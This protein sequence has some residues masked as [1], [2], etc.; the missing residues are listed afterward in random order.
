MPA[1]GLEPVQAICD[2]VARHVRFDYQ[3]A[4]ATRSAFDVFQERVGVCRDYAHL[5]LTFCRCFNIPARYCERVS[6]RYRCSVV[7]PMDFSAWIEVYLE[8]GW[9]TF[10]RATTFLG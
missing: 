1:S 6:R 5:A 8:G 2:F 7:E 4:R 9:H 10:D 3:Q